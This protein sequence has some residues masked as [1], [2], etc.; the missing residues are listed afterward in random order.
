M[1]VCSFSLGSQTISYC[2]LCLLQEVER[3]Y[4]QQLAEGGASE[5]VKFS[6]AIYLIKSGYKNDI[7]KGIKLMES[8]STR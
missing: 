5:D 8:E 3:R 6:Y 2:T 1:C 4:K 7:R